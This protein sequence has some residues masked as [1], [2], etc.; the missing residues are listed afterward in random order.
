LAT[1]WKN[2]AGLRSDAMP[3]ALV[4]AERQHVYACQLFFPFLR[5]RA[6]CILKTRWALLKIKRELAQFTA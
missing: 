3:L 2:S 4:F 6:S 1:V 5:E